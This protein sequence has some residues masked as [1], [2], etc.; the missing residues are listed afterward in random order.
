MFALT[1]LLFA[2][3]A[4]H[5]EAILYCRQGAEAF[6]WNEHVALVAQRV[7]VVLIAAAG[8]ADWLL[9][10]EVG[11][12]LSQLPVVVLQFSFAHNNAYNFTRLWLTADDEFD[13]HA[14]GRPY[15]WRLP[16]ALAR[17]RFDWNYQ[18]ATSTARFEFNGPERNGMALI[19]S[20]V[21]AGAVSFTLFL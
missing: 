10:Q 3:L 21:L 13:L 19:G 11:W 16:F 4:G 14:N 12:L 2:A 5:V 15:T 8:L 17:S 1:F 18:S 9:F 20:L 6:R 7:S